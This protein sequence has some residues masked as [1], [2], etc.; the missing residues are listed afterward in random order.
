MA[1]GYFKLRQSEISLVKK[2]TLQLCP[3]AT[4]R[5]EQVWRKEAQSSAVRNCAVVWAEVFQLG[6]CTF[7]FSSYLY[8]ALVLGKRKSNSA[9]AQIANIDSNF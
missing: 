3:Q 9:A 4:V 6:F 5:F 8:S 1:Y 7:H 2:G